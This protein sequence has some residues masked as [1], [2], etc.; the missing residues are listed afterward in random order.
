MPIMLSTQDII[1]ANVDD[2]KDEANQLYSLSGHP[3]PF[4]I[5]GGGNAYLGQL[6]SIRKFDVNSRRLM[7]GAESSTPLQRRL[8]S[9][10]MS[11]PTH[12]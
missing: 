10:M 11:L 1:H 3:P 4:G 9:L 8:S 6:R 2:F 7:Y 12:I 5:L